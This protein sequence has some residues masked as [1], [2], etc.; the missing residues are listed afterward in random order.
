MAIAG[1]WLWFL[2]FMI[3]LVLGCTNCSVLHMQVALGMD[4][5]VALQTVQT[6]F[7]QMVQLS[8]WLALGC[9]NKALVLH[10]RLLGSALHD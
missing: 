8:V 10:H 1:G 9:A 3:V 5:Q 7:P 6:W 2:N 4:M